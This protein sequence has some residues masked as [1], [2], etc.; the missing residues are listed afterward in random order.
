MR[1]KNY[2]DSAQA[3]NSIA[4]TRRIIAKM[5]KAKGMIGKKKKV[6]SSTYNTGKKKTTKQLGG[7]LKRAMKVQAGKK[8]S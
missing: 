3:M 5:E 4:A 7:Q 6:V 1:A 2:K 8:L